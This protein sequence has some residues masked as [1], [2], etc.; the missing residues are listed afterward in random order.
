MNISNGAGSY[1]LEI[2]QSAIAYYII[3]TIIHSPLD[4][5]NHMDKETQEHK[6]FLEELLEWTKEQ[7]R[8][9]VEIDISYMK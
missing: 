4:E 1:S 2:C 8:I 7:D 3:T 5:R 9:L 6:K